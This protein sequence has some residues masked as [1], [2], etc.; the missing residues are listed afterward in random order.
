MFTITC[1]VLLSIGRLTL[2]ANLLSVVVGSSQNLSVP[3]LVF[4]CISLG[5]GV[6][7]NFASELHIVVQVKKRSSA[8]MVARPLRIKV[9]I[10]AALLAKGSMARGRR[11]VD[12]NMLLAVEHGLGRIE[13]KQ[14]PA[15]PL[16]AIVAVAG[17]QLVGC[18]G[19]GKGVRDGSA[20]TFSL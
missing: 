14:D 9:K 10:G 12:G 7:K 1:T 4:Q 8:N 20:Q 3:V 2:K 15:G 17:P 11:V 13:R 6:H 16:S 5:T 18:F 19:F